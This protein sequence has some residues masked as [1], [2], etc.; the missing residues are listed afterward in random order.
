A[1]FVFLMIFRT[2]Y[3]LVSENIHPFTCKHDESEYFL[4]SAVNSNLLLYIVAVIGASPKSKKAKDLW[5]NPRLW[6]F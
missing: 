4:K 3:T 1:A 6:L 5:A 2:A